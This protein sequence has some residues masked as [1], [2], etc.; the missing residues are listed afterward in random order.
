MGEDVLSIWELVQEELRRTDFQELLTGLKLA[1]GE[2]EAKLRNEEVESLART[3]TKVMKVEGKDMLPGHG[4]VRPERTKIERNGGILDFDSD[5]TARGRGKEPRGNPELDRQKSRYQT[6]QQEITKE[7]DKEKC[8]T[9]V[10]GV[11]KE[12]MP[13]VRTLKPLVKAGMLQKE[14]AQKVVME[15]LGAFNGGGMKPFVED[16]GILRRNVDTWRKQVVRATGRERLQQQRPPG[17]REKGAGTEG[18]KN[19]QQQESLGARERELPA[20]K[21]P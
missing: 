18:S 8:L 7:R 16:G 3:G 19:C 12:G 6:E 4:E 21:T 5:P 11:D 17:A 13:K 20:T 2:L 10:E 14:F 9:R 1:K 15:A